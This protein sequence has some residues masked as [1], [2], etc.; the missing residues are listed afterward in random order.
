MIKPE[1]G[2]LVSETY[3]LKKNNIKMKKDLIKVCPNCYDKL[4]LKPATT[5]TGERVCDG[6]CVQGWINGDTSKK[7]LAIVVKLKALLDD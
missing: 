1:P 7:Y 2:E 6:L 5:P 4:P 3:N